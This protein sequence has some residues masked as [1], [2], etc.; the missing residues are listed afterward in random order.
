MEGRKTYFASDFHLGLA[1]GTDPRER[2]QRVITW[3]GQVSHDAQA[4]Y[5]LGDVFDFWWEYKTVIPRGFSR[6]LGTIA[7]LTDRG[8]EVHVF[9]GNHDMWMQGY[10]AGECGVII[11]YEPF[12][13]TIGGELFY[14]AH[15]EGLGSRSI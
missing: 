9:T 7:S 11:H 14:L 2:E 10:L 15:G 4:I 12:Q 8:I 3:L 6:F 13:T 1:A 5:L